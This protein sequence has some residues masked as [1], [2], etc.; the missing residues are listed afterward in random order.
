MI[1]RYVSSV[2]AVVVA[3]LSLTEPARAQGVSFIRDAET[4][5]TIREIAAPLFA[6]AGLSPDAVKLTLVNDRSLNA[7]VSG[8]QRVFIHTGLLIRVEHV[9]QLMGV[10]AH[11]TGHI[12]GGH[13]TRLPQE[14]ER[15]AIVSMIESVL[16][17]GAM[18]AGGMASNRS[19]RDPGY[20]DPNSGRVM[21]GGQSAAAR[22]F[23]AFTRSQESAAD[24]AGVSYLESIQ[25]SSRGLMEFMEVLSGQELQSSARQDPYMR[26]HPLT[27][28]RIEFL[29]NQVQRSRFS[30][31][32]PP[33]DAN[34]KF[35]RIQ[36]KLVG[37]LEAP[38][39]VTQRY[40]ASDTS[41]D[42]NY[43][44]TLSAYRALDFT[45]AQTLLDGLLTR[46]PEDPYF[47]E[48]KGQILFET[49][50]GA[51]AL[52]YYEKAVR[53]TGNALLK[54]DL[55]QVRIESNDKAQ[56]KIAQRELE[57][58]AL[59]ERDSSKLWRLLAI[60]YGRD[61]QLGQAAMASAEQALLE[62]RNR[63]ARDQAK[64]AQRLLPVGST[65]YIRAQDIEGQSM[66]EVEDEGNRR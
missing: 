44:R 57:E 4:E 26:T 59:V 12:A 21:G 18:I 62:G 45:K 34:A 9:G 58:A 17:M 55:A 47:N 30:D 32:P 5:T 36:A 50:K 10:I 63:D 29:R 7:F 13:L 14:Y 64:R 35:H 52:P 3:S 38:Y 1:K 11:E 28:E 66:R 31:V 39:I 27:S 61:E 48:L 6:A 49:G 8:G 56:L 23:F 46:S 41:I 22:T 65:G 37:Y 24:Q 51:Q 54:I 19:N 2:L 40:P 33:A 42:A 53:Y 25:Q 20:R 43:A 60:A 16:A 15:A